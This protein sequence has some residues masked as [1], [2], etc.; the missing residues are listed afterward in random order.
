L[1]VQREEMGRY[2]SDFGEIAS[3]LGKA[4]EGSAF[5]WSQFD[6][7]TERDLEKLSGEMERADKEAVEQLVRQSTGRGSSAAGMGGVEGGVTV[8]GSDV[9]IKDA[10]EKKVQGGRPGEIRDAEGNLWSACVLDTDMVQ[11]TMPGNRVNTHRA[12]VV[13]GNLRGAAGY[14]MGK[15]KTGQDAVSA[16]CRAAMRNVVHLDLFDNYGLA[17]DL[18][19]RHNSC[20]CYIK[21][22]PNAREMV[23]SPFATEVL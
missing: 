12:L 16:A 8:S 7:D 11:K 5:D 23:A 18:Y 17:H 19:G 6:L 13:V 22:T 3:L 2:T 14:G 15:G 4:D 10:E 20:H 21:A 9:V 1:F